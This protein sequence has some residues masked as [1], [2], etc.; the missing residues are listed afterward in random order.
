MSQ[1]HYSVNS[2]F[3][4]L[5]P[6]CDS[7]SG[8]EVQFLLSSTS[9]SD[10]SQDEPPHSGLAVVLKHCPVKVTPTPTYVSQVPEFTANIGVPV[11]VFREIIFFHLFFSYHFVY[12]MV[13]QM[14]IYAEQFMAANPNSSFTKP[15]MWTPTNSDELRKFEGLLLS[16]GIIIIINNEKTQLDPTGVVT[17]YIPPLCMPPYCPL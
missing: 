3:A 7:D 10:S 16:M 4:V 11:D 6:E 12:N 5:W 9:T 17:Y 15:R 13:E 14:Q 2:S 1:Q 8:D